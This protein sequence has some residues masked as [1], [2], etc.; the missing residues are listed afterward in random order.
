MTSFARVCTLTPAQEVFHEFNLL[1]VAAACLAT[2]VALRTGASTIFKAGSY[3][4]FDG[5]HLDL[6]IR[7]PTHGAVEAALASKTPGAI[8]VHVLDGRDPSPTFNLVTHGFANYIE[9]LV[10][11]LLV[12]YFQRCR[13]RVEARFGDGRHTW[14]QSWQAGWAVRNAASHA[15]RSFERANQRPVYWR[16]LSH[17]PLDEPAKS[18]IQLLNCADLMVLLLDMEGDRL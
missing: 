14:P 13:A 8:E 6:R 16:G 11:P 15:G 12:A 17:G 5:R 10:P 3:A 7:L 2:A 18:I 4:S 1:V 9:G